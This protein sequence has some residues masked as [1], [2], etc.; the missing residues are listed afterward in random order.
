MLFFLFSSCHGCSCSCS[1]SSSCHSCCSSCSC[2]FSCHSSCCCSSCSCS[3]TCHSSCCS[4]CCYGCSC[5]CFL[6]LF[7]A[8]S[9]FML[10]L[11]IVT[12]LHGRF[13]LLFLCF[14]LLLLLF[15]SSS[16]FLFLLH[17]IKQTHSCYN[18]L[19][20]TTLFVVETDCLNLP[21]IFMYFLAINGGELCHLVAA[22][23]LLPRLSHGQGQINRMH[24]YSQKTDHANY[25]YYILL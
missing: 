22:T 12:L 25:Y 14:L 20:V 19:F 11:I 5:Y 15:S 23:R 7:Y 6:L 4:S 3:S 21:F 24:N 2:S 17:E 8:L 10:V 16:S 13:L 9:F 1:C 18:P